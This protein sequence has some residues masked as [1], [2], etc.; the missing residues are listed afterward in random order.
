MGNL[1]GYASLLHHS[2]VVM[3]L[4]RMLLLSRP[5][6]SHQIFTREKTSFLS[7]RHTGQAANSH[8][9]CQYNVSQSQI[10]C[11]A[12]RSPQ[13]RVGLQ[14]DSWLGCTET[15]AADHPQSPCLPGTPFLLSAP[16][17]SFLYPHGVSCQNATG[18]VPKKPHSLKGSYNF[19]QHLRLWRKGLL[20]QW[21]L[22][23]I[24]KILAIGASLSIAHVPN[25]LP[26]AKY[27]AL[28]CSTSVNSSSH[29][30]TLTQL[31]ECC[32]NRFVFSFFWQH[33]TSPP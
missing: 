32:C 14:A 27:R 22:T 13:P 26:T 28:V 30:V 9:I 12:C 2:V 25:L 17:A 19:K 21:R 8:S 10:T 33:S 11:S 16:A 31:L 1:G 7:I 18:S 6:F 4:W 24:C 15:W 29:A 3:A 23:Y 20:I 5:S